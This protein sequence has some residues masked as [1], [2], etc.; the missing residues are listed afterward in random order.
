M[1][2]ERKGPRCVQTAIESLFG[3]NID[4]DEARYVHGELLK[5]YEHAKLENPEA[6]KGGKVG[7]VN[8][9][10]NKAKHIWEA[11]KPLHDMAKGAAKSYIKEKAPGYE[12]YVDHAHTA[13]DYGMQFAP[14]EKES[15]HG[16][17]HYYNQARDMANH[18]S[19]G[20]GQYLDDIRSG[21]NPRDVAQR[22]GADARKYV[23]E[24]VKGAVRQGM[25]AG[26]HAANQ[27]VGHVENLKQTI[28]QHADRV[29]RGVQHTESQ[30]RQVADQAR[31]HATRAIDQVNA[32]KTQVQAAAQAAHAHAAQTVKS[33]KGGFGSG[34]GGGNAT[35]EWVNKTVRHHLQKLA[36]VV[37]KVRDVGD[38]VN[39]HIVRADDF[40]K[41]QG[42]SGGIG[43]GLSG[44]GD[45]GAGLCGAGEG[46]AG[47]AG[48]GFWEDIHPFNVARVAANRGI[49][50]PVP[51]MASMAAE[52]GVKSIHGGDFSDMD[53][54]Y[55]SHHQFPRRDEGEDSYYGGAEEARLK[56]SRPP[57]PM[58]S[59]AVRPGAASRI[60][61][62]LGAGRNG[63]GR[64][65][66]VTSSAVAGSGFQEGLDEDDDEP[67]ETNE[68]VN[69]AAARFD[70]LNQDE[71]LDGGAIGPDWTYRGL[72]HP[73]IPLHMERAHST[74]LEGGAEFQGQYT[75]MSYSKSFL[76]AHPELRGIPQG[77]SS[78]DAV[79]SHAN[80]SNGARA[81]TLRQAELPSNYLDQTTSTYGT[82]PRFK[83][84]QKWNADLAKAKADHDAHS[85][86]KVNEKLGQYA[87]N[88]PGLGLLGNVVQYGSA[89]MQHL[90]G[91]GLYGGNLEEDD[92]LY[93]FGIPPPPTGDTIFGGTAQED[94]F[95]GVH[96]WGPHSEQEQLE[97]HA[98]L[99]GA[100]TKRVRFEETPEQFDFMEAK[101]SGGAL[102]GTAPGGG[103]APVRGIEAYESPDEVQQVRHAL[104]SSVPS[105]WC[106]PQG[107]QAALEQIAP[108][109]GPPN[110]IITYDFK[111]NREPIAGMAGMTGGSTKRSR[112]S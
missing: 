27:A 88:I 46:G 12:K 106:M 59:L 104:W 71:D 7:V 73:A 17:D 109:E 60:R 85:I 103:V 24:N 44:A 69:E 14:G 95:L 55:G 75:G 39:G 99:V 48:A 81:E 72:R 41:G 37:H 47:F 18:Y 15:T 58:T 54:I 98:L 74:S 13:L 35:E 80:V 82:M 23:E 42:L 100:G 78:N 2:Y 64:P 50:G 66:M 79:F 68:Y 57:L 9:L 31:Q 38:Y 49:F 63:R 16:V 61:P 32:A 33:K 20:S 3:G 92:A 45:G 34:L 29:Q 105:K 52:G 11:T 26:H 96:G 40:L 53:F 97:D 108:M 6:L 62:V 19:P 76:A 111:N 110:G 102:P 70:E 28:G 91:Q 86:W 101:F 90:D 43:M 112:M 94:H 89:A 1:P 25:A 4:S 5:T 22:A 83:A 77:Y 30:V 56:L 65:P 87:K 21:Q 107:S 10:Y 8:W 36:P 51:Q 84:D 67:D 93:A